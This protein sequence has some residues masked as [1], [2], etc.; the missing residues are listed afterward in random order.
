MMT[1]QNVKVQQWVSTL[2]IWYRDLVNFFPFN[3]S[4]LLKKILKELD[5]G[6]ILIKSINLSCLKFIKTMDHKCNGDA[7]C[8]RWE[9]QK[10]QKRYLPLLS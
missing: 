5:L 9:A 1:P 4:N 3:I 2:H 6:Y 7:K 10:Q 8:Q